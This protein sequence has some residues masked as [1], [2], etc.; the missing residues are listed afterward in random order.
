LFLSILAKGV[1]EEEFDRELN[2]EAN[3]F[4][5]SPATVYTYKF[6]VSTKYRGIKE[7]G[8]PF[9]LFLL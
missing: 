6:T 7:G 1:P 3:V 5:Y 9:S 8:L 4:H 2:R